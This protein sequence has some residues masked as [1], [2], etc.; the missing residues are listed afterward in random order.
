MA[1][2]AQRRLVVAVLFD[3]AQRRPVEIPGDLREAFSVYA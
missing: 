2:V 1:T 3:L